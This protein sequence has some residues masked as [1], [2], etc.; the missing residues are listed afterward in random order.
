MKRIHGDLALRKA[1]LALDAEAHI[2]LI[3]DGHVG[4]WVKMKN[5]AGGAPMDGVRPVG[6]TKKWWAEMYAGRRHELVAIKMA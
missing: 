6:L 5:G 3:V 1:L 4:D 2:K